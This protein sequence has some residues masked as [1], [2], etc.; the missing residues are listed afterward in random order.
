MNGS[1]SY[2][3]G[4]YSQGGGYGMGGYGGGQQYNPMQS[5]GG[6]SSQ[7]PFQS[8]FGYRQ[9]QYNPMQGA[10]G[11]SQQQ[12]TSGGQGFG[13]MGYRSYGGPNNSDM[14]GSAAT[15]GGGSVQPGQSGMQT[16]ATP[17]LHPQSFGGVSYGTVPGG[18][19]GGGSGPASGL[20]QAT[21]IGSGAGPA[22]WNP[23]QPAPTGQGVAPPGGINYRQPPQWNPW[24]R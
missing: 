22:P 13:D 23:Y 9:P 15:M 21:P 5:G 16:A 1:N 19:G 24:S 7:S 4:G 12:P 6:I 20:P 18:G 14:T 17:W 8:A 11:M 10:G 2:G 3:G